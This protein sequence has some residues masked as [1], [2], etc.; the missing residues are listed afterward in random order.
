MGFWDKLLRAEQNMRRRVENAFGHGATQ[1]PLEVRR[2]ILEQVESRI[3]IDKG[4]RTFPFEEIVLRLQPSTEALRDVFET[5]FLRD[6]SLQTDIRQALKDA[7]AR[8]P[9]GLQIIVEAAAISE[10][11]ESRTSP[12]S[13]FDLKFVKVD[14]LR[15]RTVPEAR[16]MITKGS[17][18]QAEYRMKKEHILIGRL[19]EVLDREGRMIRRNDLVFLD[20]GDD[21][22]S[23]VGRIHARIWFDPE[24]REFYIMDKVSRYGTRII[25]RGRSIE[26][27]GG[28]LRGIRLKSGDEIYFGQACLRFELP[29]EE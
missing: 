28:N 17:A 14:P 4:G 25:R 26:V 5:A 15:G 18:E 2:Q 7:E 11:D 22:N 29:A 6:G 27:P 12:R 23:T 3:V 8:H 21:I 10:P 20:N 16:L 9:E 13:L 19:P 24:N 1:T